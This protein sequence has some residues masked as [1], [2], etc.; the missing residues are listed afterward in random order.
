MVVTLR[1]AP[2]AEA[3]ARTLSFTR[4]V[5]RRLDASSPSSRA[6]L[7]AVNAAQ[8]RAIAALSRAIPEARISLRYRIVLDGFT[9]ALPARRLSTLLRL[10]F[11]ERVYPAYRYTRTLNRSPAVIGASALEAATGA[12]GDGV[13]IAIVDDGIDQTN[14]FFSPSG[15]AYPPGFPKGNTAFTT[16]KVIVARAFPGPGSGDAGR[17]PLDRRSSFHGTHVA[18]IAAGDVG[19]TATPGPDHPLVS[20]LS[21]VAP[22]AQLGNY[23]VFN[24]PTPLGIQIAETP[25]IVAA[26]EAAVADGMEVINFSGGSG[27]SNP[28]TDALI[29]AVRNVAA[30]GVVPVIS[31][32]NDRDDFGLGTVGSPGTATDAITVAAVSNAHVFARALRLVSP[33]AADLQPVAVVLGPRGAPSA[34]TTTDQTLVDVGTIAGSDGKPVERHL[35]GPPGDPNGGRSTLPPGSLR[36]AVALVSRGF[37]TFGSKAERVLAAGGVGMVVV[38]NRPGEANPIPIELPLPTA[39]VSDL[40]GARLRDALAGSGGR[41]AFRLSQAS[42]EIQTERGGV[43][44]SFSAGGPTPFGH[45]LKPDIAAPG[46]QILSSTLTEFAG[47]PFA[48]FDGTSMSAPH[49]AG[50]AALLLERHPAWTPRQVK[51]ALMST[52]G[53]AYS[54]TARTTEASV[55]LEGA[56]LVRLEEADDPRIFTDPP[57]LSFGDLDTRAGPASRSIALTVTDAG[58]GA[59]IWQVEVRPQGASP[60][61]SL[62][63]P[64]SVTVPAGGS[65]TITVVARAGPAAPTG[66]SFGFLVLGRGDVVRRVPYAFFVTR[67]ALA[68]AT[69]V[70]LR[71]VQRGDTRTGTDRARV[72]R[73]PTAP[74]GQP[75]GYAAG[76]PMDADGNERVYVTTLTKPAVNLGAVVVAASGESFPV[77]WLLGALDE[78]AV[79][80]LAGTPANVN[81]L[82]FDYRFVVGAAGASFPSPG[83]YYVVVDS[84]RDAFTGRSLAGGYVLRSWVDDLEPPKIELLTTRVAAGRP[85]IALRVTDA[86]SGVDPL[87]LTIGYRGVLLGASAFDPEGGL[88][89][90]T[91]PSQAPPLTGRTPLQMI[92]SDYQETKNV[93]PPPGSPMPNTSFARKELQVVRGPAISWLEPRSGSCL[94]RRA[95]LLVAAS[96]TATISSVLFYDGERRLARIKRNV[97]GLYSYTWSTARAAKGVHR[98]TAVVADTAGFE[99]RSTVLAK[100]CGRR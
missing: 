92:A 25:E 40:D 51:S 28:A 60:G 48:V 34:W 71:P 69:P 24:V 62:E 77:P 68:A 89:V 74:F 29:E 30:A 42:E 63:A 18:G 84:G 76:K 16:P 67:P 83:R 90:F 45:A 4:A 1:L 96:D 75:P 87:S 7:R 53:P 61:A 95:R 85:T 17:L 14:P 21:G 59:G 3:H 22:R 70:P 88:A 52:A 19:T 65:A 91:L 50:A 15:F 82:M 8:R 44:T 12:R 57:S 80:G 58:G 31:A 55:L 99:A 56:G 5:R 72:Y 79:Q 66:D 100:I 10:R 43:P 9:V 81:G 13:K 41:A 32:G 23:R 64:S 38:D 86:A 47:A 49:V 11:V 94:P 27:E 26:F 46:G 54:D 2:L 6:Y 37:C 35:C 73:F 20:G 93:N 33:P 97:A 98:L 39:M 78:N 36:G